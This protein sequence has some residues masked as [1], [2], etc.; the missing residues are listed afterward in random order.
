VLDLN[1]DGCSSKTAESLLK[2]M[3][4]FE[5]EILTLKEGVEV[6]SIAGFLQLEEMAST[7]SSKTKQLLSNVEAAADFLCSVTD[8]CLAPGLESLEKKCREKLLLQGYTRPD[9]LAQVPCLEE[10]LEHDLFFVDGGEY[11]RAKLIEEIIKIR[12]SSIETAKGKGAKRTRKG[13]TKK[14]LSF[15]TRLREQCCR[16][17]FLTKQELETD[18]FLTLFKSDI[19]NCIW[20]RIC[21]QSAI[22]LPAPQRADFRALRHHRQCL[23]FNIKG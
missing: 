22:S 5:L 21:V 13:V 17:E 1:D 15:E 18:S 11:E 14:D 9:L 19:G 8:R 12:N 10:I 20:R 23:I 16:L 6:I 4:G 3:Y 7:A 2:S